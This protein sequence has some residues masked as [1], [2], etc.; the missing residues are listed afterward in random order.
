MES[1]ATPRFTRILLTG[2][3]G[4]GKT[5]ICKKIFE[6]AQ[7]SKHSIDGFYTEEVRSENRTRIGFDVV[8][9]KQPVNRVPLARIESA[10]NGQK[11][12]K[13]KVGSVNN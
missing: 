6:K 11:P 1:G 9:L 4:I 7:G 2:P 3:P 5:T 10:L 12:S 13:L 8:P